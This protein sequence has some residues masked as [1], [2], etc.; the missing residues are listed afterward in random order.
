VKKLLALALMLVTTCVVLVASA[1]AAP[2]ALKGTVGPGFTIS[3]K[4]G[5]KGVKTLKAGT[6]KLVVADKASIHNFEL[7]GPGVKNVE[8]DVSATG[9]KTFTVKLK[10]GTY[11]F[12]CKPHESSMH[13]TFTVK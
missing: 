8:T 7:E 2:P 13:G 4:K 9:T 11:T 1:S 5:G 12:Y 6:Y 10:K 3:L